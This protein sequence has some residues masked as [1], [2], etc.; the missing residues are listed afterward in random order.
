MCIHEDLSH[1]R[2]KK[3]KSMDLV[4]GEDKAVGIFR[5]SVTILTTLNSFLR[6]YSSNLLYITDTC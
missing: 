1:K 6:T 5:L 4:L 3:S 2:N